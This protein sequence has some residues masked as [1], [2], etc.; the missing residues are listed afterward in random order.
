LPAGSSRG[1]TR[2]HQREHQ[3]HHEEHA[4]RDP[5]DRALDQLGGLLGDLRLGE[6]D[7]LGTSRVA[8][9]ET[10]VIAVAMF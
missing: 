6:L 5:D 7:L 10:W 8:R 3:S 9:S 4:R 1:A 2:I